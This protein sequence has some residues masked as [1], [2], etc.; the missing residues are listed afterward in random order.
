VYDLDSKDIVPME[1]IFASYKRG[2]FEVESAG[3]PTV[4][5]DC[6]EKVTVDIVVAMA[7]ILF[8]SKIL[9]S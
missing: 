7:K 8:V 2:S 3:R 4:L 5:P 6:V 1:T 9:W